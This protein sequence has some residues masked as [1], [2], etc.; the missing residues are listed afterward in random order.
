MVAGSTQ[1]HSGRLIKN[2]PSAIHSP[3]YF[4]VTRSLHGSSA[5]LGR[6]SNRAVFFI[7]S[8]GF[9]VF[10]ATSFWSVCALWGQQTRSI[11]SEGESDGGA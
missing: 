3:I 1:K 9:C 7:S 4:G 6:S 8:L 5:V 11:E 2:V 10:A